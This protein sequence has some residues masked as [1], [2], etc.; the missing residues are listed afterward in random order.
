MASQRYRAIDRAVSLLAALAIAASAAAC[1]TGR[2]WGRGAAAGAIAGTAAGLAIPLWV[3]SEGGNTQTGIVL[4]SAAGG[5]VIGALIGHYLLDKKVEP[6]KVAALPPPPPPAPPK[7]IAV[8]K[9]AHF[10]FDSAQLTPAGVAALAATIDTLE[11]D[12]NLR[13][14]VDGHTD[15]IGS[16]AYNLQLSKRRAD[17]VKRHLAAEGIAADRIETRGLGF[18]NPAADNTTESGRAENRRVELHKQP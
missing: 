5:A 13:V 2:V 9:G 4:G 6:P 14:R 8:L 1:S 11:K 10:A 12:P 7:P 17:A 3:D 16:E 15:S 18:A